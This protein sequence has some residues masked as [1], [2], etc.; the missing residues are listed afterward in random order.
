MIGYDADREP[1]HIIRRLARLVF[2]VPDAIYL[3]VESVDVFPNFT[4]YEII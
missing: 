4:F 2:G 3:Y 1:W